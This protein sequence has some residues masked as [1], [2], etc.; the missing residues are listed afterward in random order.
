[1]SHII[2]RATQG[3]THNLQTPSSTGSHRNEPESW[4]RVQDGCLNLPQ[5]EPD[6]CYL[7]ELR[8]E[9]DF[10]GLEGLVDRICAFP[11]GVRTL[12][13]GRML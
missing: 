4:V 2:T 6:E 10:Y 1:M 8:T 9:A 3:I 5:Q 11:F 7:L 12:G 13:F